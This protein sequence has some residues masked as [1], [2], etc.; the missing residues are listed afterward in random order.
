MITM[1]G[2]GR[3]SVS[4]LFDIRGTNIQLSTIIKTLTGHARRL[5]IDFTRLGVLQV[6]LVQFS[7]L[8]LSPGPIKSTIRQYD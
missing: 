3:L 8:P 7:N 6:Y 2:A 1:S 5:N 4:N